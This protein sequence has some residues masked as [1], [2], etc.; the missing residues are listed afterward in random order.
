MY[1]SVGLRPEQIY[2]VGKVS[3][4]QHVF[5]KVSIFIY[6]YFAE[7]KEPCIAE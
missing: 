6:Y 5:A 4:K 3:K 2:V 1:S 7:E